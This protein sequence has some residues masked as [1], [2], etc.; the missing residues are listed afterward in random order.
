MSQN[1]GDDAG[2]MIVGE[3]EE[4][5]AQAGMVLH[6][7]YIASDG[8]ETERQVY[9]YR[10]EMRPNGL[11]LLAFCFMR[12]AVRAFRVDRIRSLMNGRTGEFIDDPV[13]FL[14]VIA[15]QVEAPKRPERAPSLRVPKI[16]MKPAREIEVRVPRLTSADYAR[17]RDVVRPACIALMSMARADGTLHDAEIEIVADLVYEAARHLGMDVPR[18]SLAALI[19]EMTGLSPS[20]N[21]VTRAM[22]A[23]R[24]PDAFPLDL[25]ARL[26]RMA[27]ADGLA[28]E[29]E[30][31][32]FRLMITTLKRIEIT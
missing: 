19:S 21:L 1:G 6:F 10:V 5:V 26:T 11:V 24:E 3:I 32:A 9:I 25:P 2:D 22:R 20:G 12:D 17:V 29:E 13:A 16:A 14:S 30:L 23:L 18:E 31:A 28:T 15:Q 4:D 8:E 27:R 7:R